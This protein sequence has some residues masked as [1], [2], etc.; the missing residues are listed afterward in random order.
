MTEVA[1]KPN[2][3]KCPVT[4]V[5]VNENGVRVCYRGNG[6]EDSRGA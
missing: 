4:N 2:G 1:W 6:D 5:V 3:E